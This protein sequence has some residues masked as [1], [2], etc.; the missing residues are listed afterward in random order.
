MHKRTVMTLF[1]ED[2]REEK[3]G[4]VSLMGVMSDN[5]N[6]NMFNSDNDGVER[7]Q[8]NSE[9]KVLPR[10][11]VYT[12]INFDPRDK[13]KKISMKVTM[14][15]GEEIIESPIDQRLIEQSK[16]KAIEKDNLLSGIISRLEL[17]GAPLSKSGKLTVEI[18]IDGEIYLAGALNVNLI[19][20]NSDSFTSPSET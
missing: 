7:V 12:R 16:T 17:G 11:C 5:I 4:T 19:S 6:V 8:I 3:A 13:L 14:P 18:D 20:V 15:G 10:L 9:S 1:C 2:V